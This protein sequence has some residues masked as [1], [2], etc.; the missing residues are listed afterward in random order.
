MNLLSNIEENTTGSIEMDRIDEITEEIEILLR[1]CNA[2]ELKVICVD[3]DI[4]VDTITRRQALRGIEDAV[5]AVTDVGEKLRFMR[6][7]DF[8]DRWKQKQEAIF[9]GPAAEL[10]EPVM[11]ASTDEGR[12][13][14]AVA[15]GGGIEDA[16]V[17]PVEAERPPADEVVQRESPTEEDGVT[18]H[19]DAFTREIQRLSTE[20][21]I[22][23]EVRNQLEK[24]R[25]ES[26]A[27]QL[28]D[29]MR[30]IGLNGAKTSTFR[31]EFKINGIVGGKKETRLNYL[32]LCGQIS[33]A[34]QKGYEDE[35][36]CFA[37]KKAIA[38]GS[39]L[40]MY[41]DSLQKYDLQELLTCVRSSYMEKSASALFQ[42]LNKLCQENNEDAQAF[43]F[44]AL[45]LRQKVMAASEADD[46]IN[47][48]GQLIQSVFL[49]SVLT[50]LKSESIRSHMKPYLEKNRRTKDKEL[51][52]E[53][54]K[55][56]AEQNER[57]AKI[58]SSVPRCPPRVNEVTT[59]GMEE[60]VKPITET[61]AAMT[62]RMQEMQ[63]EI[64]NIKRDGK[65]S[66]KK[67]MCEKCVS[68][69]EARCKHCYKCGE[70]GHFSR[71]CQK[72]TSGD[73]ASRNATVPA[74][75][76]PS[77]SGGLLR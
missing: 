60:I 74:Q 57:C 54:C 5:E 49:H 43:L 22:R 48:D 38:A 71:N 65:P 9:R 58:G 19:E 61:M 62:L 8:P 1:R 4:N 3:L 36:I 68:S 41:I 75:L 67:S 10:T 27:Q 77:N 29:S 7:L 56:C 30:N 76:M 31:R 17:P 47:Y 24:H 66:W 46:E 33:E 69:G 53:M 12:P 21:F 52:E 25:I 18:M 32:S 34:R 37:I 39:E 40:K 72:R 42:D 2:E 23:S 55:A 15:A 16:M 26:T 50:G 28:E 73:V 11:Q 14:L 6:D 59:A 51:I 64:K 63:N 13:N 70:E 44:R 35:E 20:G 45:G